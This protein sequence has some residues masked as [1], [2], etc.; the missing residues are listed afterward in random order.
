MNITFVNPV[1]LEFDGNSIENRPLGGAETC[2]INLSKELAKKH[3]VTVLCNC[4]NEGVY[5]KVEYKDLY[6]M[7]KHSSDVAIIL[8]QPFMVELFK[9]MKITAKKK[10]LW[11]HDFAATP[12]HTGIRASYKKYKKIVT[13]SNWH[14]KD[15]FEFFQFKSKV[16]S[17]FNI[18]GN[19]VDTKIF[20][21]RPIKIKD[22]VKLIYSSTPFRGLDVLHKAFKLIS[23]KVDAELNVYSSMKVYSAS[24]ENFKDLYK[25]LKLT[26]GINYHGS[27]VQR[28]LARAM[29]D[30]HILSYP[31]TYPE[32]YCITTQEAIACA[33]PIATTMLG[34][35]AETVPASCVSYSIPKD[36]KSFTNSVLDIVNNYK[37]Y[38]KRTKKQKVPTWKQRAKEWRKMIE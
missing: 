23:K 34:A 38:L 5:D 30:S 22:K 13:L 24:D 27:V 29:M 7:T 33:T 3:N 31:S 15:V 14:M 2:I 19:A 8:R 12:V 36:A 35:L 1:S 28:E 18:I 37:Y 10:Y 16:A 20:K 17:K 26:K 9:T 11:L 21:K 32:T 6:T 4:K 25:K